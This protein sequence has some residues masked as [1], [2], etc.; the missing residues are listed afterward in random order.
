MMKFSG[1]GMKTR[2]V[3]HSLSCTLVLGVRAEGAEG[4]E[5]RVLT[6]KRSQEDCNLSSSFPGAAVGPG[7][8]LEGGFLGA[9]SLPRPPSPPCLASLPPASAPL[10]CP[11]RD[12]LPS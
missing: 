12:L 11:K 10:S 3:S 8:G 4:S 5:G 1:L 7:S 2:Q 6:K 9:G